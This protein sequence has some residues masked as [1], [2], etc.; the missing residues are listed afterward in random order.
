MKFNGRIDDE[1]LQNDDVKHAT[2]VSDNT[3]VVTYQDG[4]SGVLCLSRD[5]NWQWQSTSELVPE[6]AIKQSDHRS[7]A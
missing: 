5:I 3:I 7:D 6:C 4:S 2:V 1:I